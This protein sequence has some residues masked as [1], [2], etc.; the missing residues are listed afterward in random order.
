VG[1]GGA[2]RA[3]CTTATPDD[4]GHHEGVALVQA[5]P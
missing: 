5:G 3:A 1:A 2:Y 4:H